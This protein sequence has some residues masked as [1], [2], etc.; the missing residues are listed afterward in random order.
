MSAAATMPNDHPVPFTAFGRFMASWRWQLGEHVTVVGPAGTGKTTLLRALVRKRYAAGGAVVVLATKPRDRNLTSWA[1]ADGL[2]VVRDWPPK[3]PQFWRRPSDI[4][5][6]DGRTL[7]WEHRVMVWPQPGPDDYREVMA[8]VHRRALHELFW[9]GNVCI[10]GEE[11]LYLSTE[12]GLARDLV[13]TWT[14]GRSNGV[15]LLGATQRP[16]DIPL[17]AYSQASHLFMFGD[18]DEVNLRR[19]Q[20]I[21]GMSS[22]RLRGWVGEL[23]FHDVLYI[24]TRGRTVVRTRVP[25][26]MR[27]AHR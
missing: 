22:T 11:L 3:P 8:D 1:R 21:G 25:I 12:L 5:T 23:P 15:S 24:D 16:V 27:G 20:G 10:V 6:P 4:I 7:S 9:Q 19:L 18:N 13:T 14:Q 26:Q 2:T 17:Y